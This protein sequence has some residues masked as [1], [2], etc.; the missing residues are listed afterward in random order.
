MLAL[1]FAI[2]IKG[3]SIKKGNKIKNC[4]IDGK[5]QFIIH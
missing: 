2:S 4:I 5:Q 1:A 3:E